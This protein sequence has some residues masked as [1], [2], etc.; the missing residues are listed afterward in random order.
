MT[1]ANGNG[2]YSTFIV[3]NNITASISVQF[4]E[5]APCSVSQNLV[6]PGCASPCLISNFV[7]GQ[8]GASHT[9]EVRDFDFSPSNLDVLIGDTVHFVWT[10]AIA[11]TTT[12]D[13]FMGPNSWNSGLLS[14]GATYDLVIHDTGTFPYYCQPH[15]G[16][17]GIGMSGVIHVMDTCDQESWLT[18]MS[19]DVTAG[20]P[21][22]YNVFVDG[23]KITDTPVQYQDPVGS[24]EHIINLPGD[25]SWHLVTIQDLE[26]GFCAYTTPVLTSICGAGCS[27]NNLTVNVGDNILHTVEVRDFDY[28][29]KQITVGAGEK[30]KFVWTGEIPHTVTSDALTGPEVWNS[31]LLGEGAVYEV[32]INTP[33]V[34]P[35][36]CIPHGGPNGI[37]MSGVI[38]VLPECA[39][40]KQNVQANFEVTHGSIQG[41]NLFV[42]GHLYGNNPRHYDNRRGSNEVTIQYPADNNPHI[43]TIQDLENDICAASEFFTMGSCDTTECSL[44]GLDYFLGNGR[45]HEVQVRDFDYEPKNLQI[46]L[47]DTIHFVWTGVIPHTVTSDAATGDDVFNSGLLGQGSEFDLVL[48][49]KGSHP[50]YCIPHGAPGGIGMAGNINVVDPCDDGKVFVDFIFFANGP[51]SSYD[52]SNQNNTVINDRAYQPG[53][54]QSFALELD[55]QGQTYDILVSD[56]GPSDCT[57][58]ISIDTLDCSDPCF[59]TF[60]DFDYDINYSTLEVAFSADARGDISSWHWDFDD[61]TFSDQQNPVHV[62]SEARLYEVCLT[63]IDDNGC[64]DEFCD[65]IRLG[66]DVCNASFNYQQQ[67]LDFIFY[68]TSDVSN[69]LVAATWTFGDG[70]SSTQTDSSSHQFALGLYEVC[71]TVTS[72][73]CV[74]TYCEILDLTDSCLALD[75]DYEIESDQNN[76]LSFQFTDISSGPVNSYLWGFGDGQISTTPDPLHEYA[77]TGVY[78]VCLLIMDQDGNCTDSDCRTL[79]VGTTSV[80]QEDVKMKKMMVYPNPSSTSNPKVQVSGFDPADLGKDA[81][82]IIYDINGSLILRQTIIP[83]VSNVIVLPSVAGVYYLQVQTR[84]NRYGTM[85]VIQ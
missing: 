5:N 14:Q 41:Y 84:K 24:N 36:F 1:D 69:P 64:S 46:E 77:K 13:Q 38:T 6:I 9:V 71:I 49:T 78:T 55:A 59:L 31:G 29:P 73:G 61:G 50:Y 15:G 67:G 17:G 47:G 63:I 22:G 80:N 26:T 51:G 81:S 34:H 72:T 76:P 53:G 25:G 11:H 37:G 68:N 3:G 54:V 48:S 79:F 19:F 66:A 16:P 44:S 23:V 21:L 32:I 40:N 45:R 8:R 20:S 57:G 39:D 56:N 85:V 28:F 65:K 52:V 62:F 12:S 83:E 35:Y 75:A 4:I 74:D 27:V 58:T 70:V 2:T 42:D 10:G 33:G 82:M 60:A 18:N 43:F 30:I 7:V